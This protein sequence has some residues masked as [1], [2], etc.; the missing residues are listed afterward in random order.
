MMVLAITRMQTLCKPRLVLSERFLLSR[1]YQAA[2]AMREIQEISEVLSTAGISGGYEEMETFLSVYGHFAVGNVLEWRQFLLLAKFLKRKFLNEAAVPDS[3]IAFV[4]LGG[5]SDLGGFVAADDLRHVCQ[6]FRLTIDIEAFIAEHD[7]DQSGQLEFDEF[8]GIVESHDADIAI[9]T[10]DPTK[11]LH[12]NPQAHKS[13]AHDEDDDLETSPQDKPQNQPPPPPPP[14]EEVEMTPAAILAGVDGWI[15][16]QPPFDDDRKQRRSS[17]R[18]RTAPEATSTHSIDSASVQSDQRADGKGSPTPD[19]RQPA[20]PRRPL[21]QKGNEE[22]A[23]QELVVMKEAQSSSGGS[24]GSARRFKFDKPTKPLDPAKG[25]SHPVPLRSNFRDGPPM[26]Q[27]ARRRQQQ[28]SGLPAMHS[29]RGTATD[30]WYDYN[31]F[32]AAASGAS[33]PNKLPLI[34]QDKRTLVMSQPDLVF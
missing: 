13:A 2:G 11:I 18:R 25:S 6:T 15:D 33:S 5:D 14:K 31:P 10:Y 24:F 28:E 7:D 4:A 20:K 30:K 16:T 9:S 21:W 12:R 32:S 8:S 3:H 1:M 29:A 17:R 27:T 22:R 23:R 34:A 19:G 26:A